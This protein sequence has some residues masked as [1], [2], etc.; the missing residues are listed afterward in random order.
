MSAA[1][2]WVYTNRGVW[3]TVDDGTSWVNA[4]PPHLIVAKIRGIGALDANRALLAVVDVGTSTSTYYIWRTTTAGASWTY[5]ALPPIPHDVHSPSCMPGDFCGQPGDPPASIDFV[6]PS[7]AFV[8]ISMREG[9]DGQHTYIFG[10]SDGGVHWSA[11]TFVH[12]LLPVGPDPLANVEFAT[13]TTGVLIAAEEFESTT[14]GW[15]HWTDRLLDSVWDVPHV[16][17]LAPDLWIADKGLEVGTVNAHY[18]I[19]TNQGAS[20]VDHTTAVPGLPGLGGARLTFLSATEWIGTA[21]TAVSGSSLGPSTTIYTADG[22]AHFAMYGHEPFN[23]A[24]AT[25][26]DRDHGWAGPSDPAIDGTTP[27]T[28]RLYA[29]VDRGLHWQLI[30]P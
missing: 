26:V 9:I 27:L 24:I 1:A 28:T 17:F 2:G 13:P 19:S 21:R 16:Y 29:T 15:G 20:W 18:A 25:W 7:T 23:S 3:Q 30:T 22:G 6:D 8:S 5:T 10:T 12:P 4:T 11:R 14:T